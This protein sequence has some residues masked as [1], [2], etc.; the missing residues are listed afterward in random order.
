MELIEVPPAVLK[1]DLSLIRGIDSAS[2]AHAHMLISLIS[3]AH[4]VGAKTLAEGVETAAELAA[5]SDLGIDLIQG[6]WLGKPIEG[7][8]QRADH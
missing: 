3:L 2:D 4:S 5:C 6:Y 7:F 1:L 8:Q